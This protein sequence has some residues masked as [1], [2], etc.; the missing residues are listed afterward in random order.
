V[1]RPGGGDGRL[2]VCAPEPISM[3]GRE[4]AA[5][6]MRDA[7]EAMALSWLRTERVSVSRRT[8]S[9]KVDSTVS[10]GE[11]GKKHSPSP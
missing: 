8:A 9:A 11:P 7:A 6:I 2:F 10:I 4:P 1:G 5:A 3:H